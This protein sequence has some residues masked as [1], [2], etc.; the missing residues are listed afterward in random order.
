MFSLSSNSSSSLLQEAWKLWIWMHQ[1][2]FWARLLLT[3][4]GGCTHTHYKANNTNTCYRLIIP[5]WTCNAGWWW[6]CIC[7]G[8]GEEWVWALCA[9]WSGWVRT[10]WWAVEV[11]EGALFHSFIHLHTYQYLTR[12][13]SA[14]FPSLLK[15]CVT[16]WPFQVPVFPSNDS[17]PNPV[18]FAQISM[19]LSRQTVTVA[20]CAWQWLRDGILSLVW[21]LLT[22][23]CPNIYIS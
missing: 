22:A 3:W 7:S 23:G 18:T 14:S 16:S 12:L 20:M 6:E 2:H 8:T 5:Q 21:Q 9:A 10:G 11:V 15:W 1:D 13:M 4:V 19:D 17:S